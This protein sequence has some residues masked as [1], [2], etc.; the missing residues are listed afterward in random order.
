MGS[1]FSSYFNISLVM[2]RFQAEF[3]V[4]NFLLV[5]IYLLLT[6]L[7]SRVVAGIKEQFRSNT[8]MS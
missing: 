3:R 7:R 1:L 8:F 2:P 6:L 4:F 5:Q